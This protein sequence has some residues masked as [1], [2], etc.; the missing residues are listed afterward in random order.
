MFLHNM[1][2]APKYFY[3]EVMVWPSQ[4]NVLQYA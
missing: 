3:R 1:N 2:N 4:L